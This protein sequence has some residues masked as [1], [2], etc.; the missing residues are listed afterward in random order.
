MIEVHKLDKCKLP[1]PYCENKHRVT[2]EVGVESTNLC[3]KHFSSESKK[4]KKK[5]NG[6]I[7][8]DSI[9]ENEKES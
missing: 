6:I 2:L 1:T 8:V 9:K 5:I 7:V 3:Y 4:S